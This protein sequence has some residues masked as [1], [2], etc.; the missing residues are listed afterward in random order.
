M[1]N[2]LLSLGYL[3]AGVPHRMKKGHWPVY[4]ELGAGQKFLTC[5]AKGGSGRRNLFALAYAQGRL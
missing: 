4:Y 5:C 3:I 1:T 2:N